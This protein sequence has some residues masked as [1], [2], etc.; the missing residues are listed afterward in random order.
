MS[1]FLRLIASVLV[2]A[3]LGVTGGNSQTSYFG[4]KRDVDGVCSKIL[5]S[6][7]ETRL[8][9][10]VRLHRKKRDYA[11]YD[12]FYPQCCMQ[13]KYQDIDKGPMTIPSGP[14]PYCDAGGQ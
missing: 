13:G 1:R 3:S 11:C 10:A 2:M 5:P 8:V 7:L 4:C 14:V 9:W 6:G 12:G